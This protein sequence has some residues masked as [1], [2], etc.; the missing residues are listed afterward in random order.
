MRT[1]SAEGSAPLP[2]GLKTKLLAIQ[3]L[4][5]SGVKSSEAAC[6]TQT[7]VEVRCPDI[8]MPR[9]PD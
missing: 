7:A 9:C 1:T 8:P 4:E 2:L 5:E 3:E 6:V